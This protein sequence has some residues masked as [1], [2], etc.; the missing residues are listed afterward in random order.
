M[1]YEHVPHPTLPTGMLRTREVCRPPVVGGVVSRFNTKAILTSRV[2]GSIWFA[3]V[4]AAFDCISL[5][6]TIKSSS[7]TIVA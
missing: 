5:P 7:S 6:D 2:A 1:F 4:F 3:Y